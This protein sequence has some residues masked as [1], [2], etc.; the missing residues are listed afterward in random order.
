[1][2]TL[3]LMQRLVL[4][5]VLVW[6]LVRTLQRC[7]LWRQKYPSTLLP[8]GRIE[9]TDRLNMVSQMDAEGFGNCTNTGACEVEC[10]KEFL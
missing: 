3:L 1:M 6:L 2:L 4:V 8:Q 5:V 7:C 10:P 9:A